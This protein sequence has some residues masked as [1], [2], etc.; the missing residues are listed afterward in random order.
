MKNNEKDL[1]VALHLIEEDLKYHRLIRHL[2]EMDVHIE[3]YP[4]IASAVH[5]LLC[6]AHDEKEHELWT[7]QYVQLVGDTTGAESCQILRV[8]SNSVAGSPN[9]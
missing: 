4:D 3:F 2:A 1:Q 9:P 6:S 7:N 8:L 5:M